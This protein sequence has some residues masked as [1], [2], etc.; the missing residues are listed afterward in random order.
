MSFIKHEEPKVEETCLSSEH[1]PPMHIVLKPGK[2]TY[3]CPACGKITE[4][5]IPVITCN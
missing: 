4:F 1:N 3:Q 5:E 2:H